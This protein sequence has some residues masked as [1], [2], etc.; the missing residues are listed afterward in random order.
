MP[1]CETC[2]VCGLNLEWISDGRP[3]KGQYFHQFKADAFGSY[4][5]LLNYK[6]IHVPVSVLQN[7]LFEG[8]KE[9]AYVPAQGWSGKNR[10]VVAG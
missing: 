9:E 3:G 7:D 4:D 10:K 5:L 6:F 8:L 1:M 2:A